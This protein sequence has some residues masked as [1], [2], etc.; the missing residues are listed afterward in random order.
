MSD[1]ND[2][3]LTVDP[4]GIP[5]IDPLDPN[6]SGSLG[7]TTA[8]RFDSG[9]RRIRERVWRDMRI[10]D[11]YAQ[12]LRT[13]TA[14]DSTAADIQKA[15]EAAF[16]AGG[17]ASAGGST[18]SLAELEGGGAA[19]TTV[20]FNG[21]P[22][23]IYA[24]LR[25]Q[26]DFYDGEIEANI[27]RLTTIS[28]FQAN[29]DFP[30]FVDQKELVAASGGGTRLATVSLG[31]Q[32]FTVQADTA[33]TLAQRN[34]E[35]NNLSAGE[36]ARLNQDLLEF[37]NLSAFQVEQVNDQL[38]TQDRLDEQLMFE[39][40]DAAVGR[41]IQRQQV[42]LQAAGVAAQF[43]G[44][45]LQRRGQI[46]DALAQDMAFQIEIGRMSTEEAMANLN[47]IDTALNQRRAE[48]EVLL[49][50]AVRE[51]SVRRDA[52]GQEVTTL[53]GAAQ[54]AAILGQ[55]T[56]QQFTE[57]FGTLA[58]TR[59]DPEGVGAQVLEESAFD[60]QIP[61]LREGLQQTREGINA[62]LGAPVG[63]K[64]VSDAVTQQAIEGLT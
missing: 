59:V 42:A 41:Q 31:G 63:T 47:R 62:I 21:S 3:V 29:H 53:P 37:N 24:E 16:G 40:N 39:I 7:E 50:F 38:R 12:S 5:D 54:L 45:E 51:A 11:V 6:I 8:E 15:L 56:G 23:G 60:S 17:A 61:A 30:G 64:A 48:R 4:A 35:F 33:A 14:A 36:A 2:G 22:G 32:Q 57:D 46:V 20:N 1:P 9:Y 43:G 34:F 58:T 55:S 25:R 28:P 10:R 18:S 52:T 13:M 44:L 19:G 49:Q 27:E 26:I